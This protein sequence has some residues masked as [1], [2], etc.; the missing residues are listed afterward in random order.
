M[1]ELERGTRSLP[2]VSVQSVR[3]WTIGHDKLHS[4]NMKNGS[5]DYTL[6]SKFSV[7]EQTKDDSEWA[8]PWT[9]PK[10]TVTE[11]VP[12]SSRYDTSS[13]YTM[14]LDNDVQPQTS[15][16][17]KGAKKTKQKNYKTKKGKS[18]K[19]SQKNMTY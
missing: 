9:T 16:N 17:R 13:L 4:T 12:K 18:Q 6:W 11:N 1:G 15:L 2:N 7:K 19:R 5:Q 14:Q 8:K 3:P 10:N